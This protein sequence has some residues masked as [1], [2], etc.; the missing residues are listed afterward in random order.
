MA[1]FVKVGQKCQAVYMEPLRMFIIIFQCITAGKAEVSEECFVQNDNIHF[2]S[3][4]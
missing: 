4:T 3:D 1:S 2:V